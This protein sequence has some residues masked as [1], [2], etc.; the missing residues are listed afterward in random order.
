MRAQRHKEEECIALRKSQIKLVKIGENSDS[1]Q[2]EERC[3]HNA[4]SLGLRD[5]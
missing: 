1:S 3:P 4:K 2:V 5:R